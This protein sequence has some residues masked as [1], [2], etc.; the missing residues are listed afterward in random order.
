MKKMKERKTVFRQLLLLPANKTGKIDETICIDEHIKASGNLFKRFQFSR[1]GIPPG[2]TRRI[3]TNPE[4]FWRKGNKN[5]KIFYEPIGD[6]R[7]IHDRFAKY[8]SN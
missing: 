4:S 5:G 1:Y 8:F 2:T 6:L 3:L 7:K